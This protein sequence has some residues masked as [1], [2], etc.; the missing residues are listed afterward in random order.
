M[1]INL[2]LSF[3]ICLII[4]C[5][6]N[7]CKEDNR[8]TVEKRQI[9]KSTVNNSKDEDEKYKNQKFKL[10]D[11]DLN[12][13]SKKFKFQGILKK[14]SKWLDENGENTLLISEEKKLVSEERGDYTRQSI[15]AYLY[16]VNGNS[17]PKLLWKIQDVAE[18]ICDPGIGLVSDIEVYDLDGDNIAENL[19]IYNINGT[20]QLSPLKYKLIM[21]SGEKEYSIDGSNT[22]ISKSG[23][24]TG[25]EHQINNNLKKAPDVFKNTAEKAWKLSVKDIILNN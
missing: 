2:L 18:N 9:S 12:S 14:G 23:C 8:N 6:L 21:H 20:C 19:F 22:L 7:S 25:G 5:F 15:N 17:E 24:K 4:S 16:V 11:L 10:L 13:L 3:L 1:K